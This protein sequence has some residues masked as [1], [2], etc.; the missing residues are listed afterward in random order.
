MNIVSAVILCTIVGAVGA[1]VLVAAA[2]FMA[3]EEDP[4]I[5]EVSACLAGAN[6]GGCGYAGCADYAKAV[7][8]DGVPCDKCAPGGPK[9]A[10]AIAKIMGG[11]ASAVE[12]KAVVQC[13]GSSEHCKPAYDYKGI[14]TCAAAAALYGGPKTCSFACI[15]LGDCT[16]VCKFDAIHIV[17]GV[18]KVDKDKCTGCGACANICPKQVIMIDA[19]GPR[20]PVVMCS[21]KDKGAV[22]NKL[23]TTSCIACGMCERTCKFDA[24]HV[25]DGVARVDYDKCKGCGM[26]A[27]KCP[28]H[29]ILFPLKDDPN[30]P[31]PVVKPAAPAAAPAAKPEAK[32]EAK[33]E[34]KA[35]YTVNQ[36]PPCAM[37]G[38]LFCIENDWECPPLA[39]WASSAE[40]S[41]LISR[42]SRSAER[43]KRFFHER[44][45]DGKMHFVSATL[46]VKMAERNARRRS[47]LS[48]YKIFFP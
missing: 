8:L 12:K 39:L 37:P 4:R 10:A 18:A 46:L 9:A 22:A 21:N 34:T 45:C 7:V 26:C 48:R 20:K 38:G 44:G 25:V 3:V 28:K 29:I 19:A 11:E 6:C 16:K 47:V 15:G 35:E 41:F 27:Q 42:L 40:K 31:K 2:K 36:S 24:I 32:A 13:Q 43:S 14:Q 23:C 17:D 30:P 5:E 33:P 1:I